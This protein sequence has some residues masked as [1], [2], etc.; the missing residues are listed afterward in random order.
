MSHC[1]ADHIASTLAATLLAGSFDRDEVRR[2]METVLG[3]LTRRAQRQ[4]VKHLFARLT[5]AYPPSPDW[6]RAFLLEAPSFE[7]AIVR[8]SQRPDLIQHV[9]TPARFSPLRLFAELEIP[10]L[11]T[12]GDL[13]AWLHLEPNDLDWFADQRRQHMRAR[14][15]VLQNYTYAFIPKRNGKTRLIEQPKPRL[16]SIQ[17]RILD[18]ILH[19]IPVHDQ[20]F[21]FVKGRSCIEAAAQH[22]GEPVVVSCDIANFFPV[23]RAARVHAIFRSIGYPWA[24]ARLL[25][26][27]ATTTTPLSILARMPRQNAPGTDHLFRR[28][29]LPQGAPTSP[30][31]ANLCAWR[32]DCRLSGL[33]RS[34]NVH[35]TRYADDMTFS[36]GALLAIRADALLRAVGEIVADEGFALNAAKTR[37][38]RRHVRQQ[39]TGIVVNDKL[40]VPRKDFDSLKAILFNASRS[41]WQSQN[42]EQHPDFRAHLEGRIS[43]IERLNPQRGAHLRQLFERIAW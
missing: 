14:I 28:P 37:I 1:S 40:N 20:A 5:S 22:A 38:M 35:Y 6:L 42:R 19:A 26:G 24:V 13:A 12:P 7:R 43:W 36:G 4:L 31:L 25:T 21:G 33:A 16:K 9:L 2:R 41:G 23:I 39:V 17:R 34:F 30:T 32:L 29:H 8:V 18:Q 15:P 3:P 27:L 11:T 10:R